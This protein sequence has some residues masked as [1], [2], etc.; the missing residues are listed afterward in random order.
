MIN[1][2]GFRNQLGKLTILLLSLFF[3]NTLNAFP[4]NSVDPSS[5]GFAGKKG[6]TIYV[7]KHKINQT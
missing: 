7:S 4:S 6:K 5:S 1:K 3:V 2:E